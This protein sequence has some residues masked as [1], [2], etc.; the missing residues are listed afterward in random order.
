M[1]TKRFLCYV[2][3]GVCKC[4]SCQKAA[5]LAA[6]DSETKTRA[7]LRAARSAQ[8]AVFNTKATA[9]VAAKCRA[10]AAA[11]LAK[12]APESPK[13]AEARRETPT[14]HISATVPIAGARALSNHSPSIT[15]CESVARNPAGMARPPSEAIHQPTISAHEFSNGFLA[16]AGSGTRMGMGIEPCPARQGTASLGS[17]SPRDHAGDDL[18][19]GLM[20][21]AMDDRRRSAAADTA[22]HKRP[23]KRPRSEG[24]GAGTLYAPS[25]QQPRGLAP[26]PPPGG[27]SPEA[28]FTEEDASLFPW[29]TPEVA[30]DATNGAPPPASA[31]HAVPAAPAVSTGAASGNPWG[32]A[33][34]SPPQA[35]A[36][37]GVRAE[38]RTTGGAAG[39]TAGRGEG[40]AGDDNHVVGAR[41]PLDN[42]P[43]AGAG[44]GAGGSSA[45]YSNGA[46]VGM[47]GLGPSFASSWHTDG[48]SSRSSSPESGRRPAL[49]VSVSMPPGSTIRPAQTSSAFAV[50]VAADRPQANGAS[51]TNRA[52][53][54][55]MHG[56]VPHASAP[57][58]NLTRLNAPHPSGARVSAPLVSGAHVTA[59]QVIRQHTVNPAHVA[60][61]AQAVSPVVNSSHASE[62][63]PSQFPFSSAALAAAGASANVIAA[64]RKAEA[65]RRQATDGVMA[66]RKLTEDV[67]EAKAF[68]ARNNKAAMWR[69]EQATKLKDKLIMANELITGYHSLRSK[70]EQEAR[71]AATSETQAVARLRDAEERT[72]RSPGAASP[73]ANGIS[74]WGSLPLSTAALAPTSRPGSSCS[75]TS[76]DATTGLRTSASAWSNG[77]VPVAG[78]ASTP[79]RMRSPAPLL[80]NGGGDSWDNPSATDAASSTTGPIQVAMPWESGPGSWLSGDLSAPKRRPVSPVSTSAAS[81]ANGGAR[82]YGASFQQ[83][84]LSVGVGVGVGA[85]ASVGF[86]SRGSPAPTGVLTGMKAPPPS[87]KIALSP[88][89]EMLRREAEGATAAARD[90]EATVVELAKRQK[91]AEAGRAELVKQTQ[92]ASD[93]ASK[94]SAAAMYYEKAAR[95]K[96]SEEATALEKVARAEQVAKSAEWDLQVLMGA[97]RVGRTGGF[98]GGAGGGDGVGVGVGGGGAIGGSNAVGMDRRMGGGDGFNWAQYQLPRNATTFEPTNGAGAQ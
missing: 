56:T 59:A 87:V 94:A 25:A 2:C 17:E 10:A 80:S 76:V 18:L 6:R 52:M 62:T 65:F 73:E 33:S 20:R 32:I 86:N 64:A 51:T 9:S 48:A 66:A 71:M 92:V 41:A 30:S 54:N 15:K 37:G 44:G 26:A 23:G 72:A 14:D 81:L 93:A 34:T 75:V 97:E 38:G 46:L 13:K 53:N 5:A 29:M 67:L 98:R 95:D 58:G 91:M 57:H 36:G 35:F 70:A 43:A 50:G 89:V 49:S 63:R 83:D 39:R 31:I 78:S 82:K 60:N 84:G 7:A 4:S 79:D 88:V 40:R 45:D 24:T 12:N 68:S 61:V 96:K 19:A 8:V 22:I 74:P 55:T 28:L 16:G 77:A 42:R 90:K 47:A 69:V 3:R 85:G 1:P 11:L 21:G 27:S